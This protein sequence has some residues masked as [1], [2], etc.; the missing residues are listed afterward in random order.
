MTEIDREGINAEFIII[1][2]NS[3][4]NT[5]EII[6][7]FKNKIPLQH[8][9]EQRPGKNCALNHALNTI[10]LGKIVVF[11]DDDIIPPK[12]WLKDITTACAK[13]PQYDIFGGR[14]DLV[15]PENI[16]VPQWVQ[17]SELV[18][19]V[20]FS[21][22]NRGDMP[23]EYED[24]LHPYGPNLWFRKKIFSNNRRFDETI[25]PSPSANFKMGSES[26]FLMELK[27]EGY[28][29]LYVPDVSVGHHVQ[30]K[31]LSETE[32][33]KR[34]KRCGSSLVQLYGIIGKEYYKKHP[35]LWKLRRLVSITRFFLLY[36]I[37]PY[38]S[39]KGKRM[40]NFLESRTFYTWH[41]ESLKKICNVGK[42][43]KS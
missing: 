20:L 1:D 6:N 11:T 8:L 31:L 15:W 29:F 2:N 10:E 4:D 43:S 37:A 39:N 24:N 42:F 36:K 33:K 5:T 26:S 22:H 25:G 21:E 16:I 27:K 28:K 18:R 9:F 32:A 40:H 17:E 35:F 41:L 34:A 23:C 7:S 14:I 3:L 13:F 19:S 12:S 38:T 30:T